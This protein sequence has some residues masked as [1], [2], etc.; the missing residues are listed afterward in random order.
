MELATTIA[1]GIGPPPSL[2]GE[3]KVGQSDSCCKYQGVRAGYLTSS[4]TEREARRDLSASV[5]GSVLGCLCLRASAGWAQQHA[6][7]QP[8]AS[9]RAWHGHSHT[10]SPHTSG[11]ARGPATAWHGSVRGSGT[12]G[13]SG[14][15]GF[16]LYPAPAGFC[17]PSPLAGRLCSPAPRHVP[18]ASA[19]ASP[20]PTDTCGL[21]PALLPW[22]EVSLQAPVTFEDVEVWFS[23]EEWELLEEWQRDLH[24]EVTEGTSQLLASLG[25]ALPRCSSQPEW[26]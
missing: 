5:P 3:G 24:R 23:V 22:Q 13:S 8:C 20:C 25:R 16:I 10:P 12:P 2:C 7:S 15:S 11:L 19:R 14:D 9:P 26:G 21:F 1:C 18:T 6:L 17:S 4:L